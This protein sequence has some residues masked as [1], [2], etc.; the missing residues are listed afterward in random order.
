MSNNYYP[1]WWDTTLTVFNKHVDS[2]TQVITW[3]KTVVENCFWKNAGIKVNIN[4][5]VIETDDT[6]CRIPKDDRFLEYDK[7]IEQPNDSKANYFTLRPGDIIVKGEVDDT[8]NEYRNGQRS[9]DLL[10]KYKELQGCM[11]I[12]E[13]GINVGPGRCNEHYYVK[14]I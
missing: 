5:V 13:V 6:L 4:N 3:Y 8:I 1:I 11:T 12:K 10:T 9:T 2:Q 14:G 7:W